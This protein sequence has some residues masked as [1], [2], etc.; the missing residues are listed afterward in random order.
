MIVTIIYNPYVKKSQIVY[1]GNEVE[2][3]TMRKYFCNKKMQ[4]SLDGACESA[5]KAC[6]F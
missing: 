6:K 3:D 2:N 5:E 1:N 4:N